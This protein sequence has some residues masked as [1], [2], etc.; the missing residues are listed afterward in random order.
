M[1]SVIVVTGANAELSRRE[2]EGLDVREVLN[3]PWE[4][5]MA[6]SVARASRGSRRGRR[7]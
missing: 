7:T 6:S 5:G 2:L 3:T 1:R 4:T